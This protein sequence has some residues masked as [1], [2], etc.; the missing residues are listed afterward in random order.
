[1][2]NFIDSKT[3]KN[4]SKTLLK[5][6]IFFVILLTITLPLI[7]PSQTQEVGK[8]LGFFAVIAFILSTIPGTLRRFNVSGVLN[9]IQNLLMFSR[10]QIGILMFLLAFAH[11]VFLSI[12][13]TIKYGFTTPTLFK[14]FGILALYA[15][16]PLF[17]TSNTWI[18]KKLKKNWQK[19]HNLTYLIMWFIFAH[20]A[21]LGRIN[22]SILLILA[23]TAQIMS[24]VFVKMNK[25]TEVVV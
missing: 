11:Y 24:L 13:P 23:G 1:M 6:I 9:K 3:A 20:V 22:T 14:I 17:V 19:L 8:K 4:I 12:I 2:T 15:S 16:F 21:I 25:N 18:K 7:L 5:A 10:S